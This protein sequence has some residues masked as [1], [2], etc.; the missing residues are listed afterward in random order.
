MF[1]GIVQH[2]GRVVSAAATVTG[3]RLGID[4][5]GWTHLPTH[6]ESIAINGC[7]LTL[8]AGLGVLM[9][10]VIPQTISHTT[11]GRLRPGDLVN[12][13]SSVTP[14]TLLSG[15]LVQGH[16]DAVARVVRVVRPPV[17]A[18]D[19]GRTPDI[20]SV[21]WAD[22]QYRLRIEAPTELMDYLV[23]RGSIAVDGVSLTIADLGPNWFEVAIIPTTLDLTTLGSLQP[24]D[25]V[26]LEADVMVKT[27]VATVR[28][29]MDRMA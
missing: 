29:I 19:S 9:F 20:A 4:P 14:A 8:V 7:C 10:D 17:V 26:N 15:H 12:L 28:R 13:E 1:T 22:A 11:L 16:V 27:V 25:A 18:G 2:R 6:G 24:G 21:A 3:L 5:S 23:P